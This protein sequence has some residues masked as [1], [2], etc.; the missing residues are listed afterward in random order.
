MILLLHIHAL[1][2]A[3]LVS[4]RDAGGHWSARGRIEFPIRA[5]YPQVALREGAAH[6]LAI[7]DI[8]EPVASW[9]ELKREKTGSEWDYVFRRLFYT[10]TPD[11]HRQ[12]FA[13]PLEVASVEETCGH[14]TNLD[15]HAG[16]DGA[17]HLLYLEAPHLHGFIRDRD[18][19]G[20]PMNRLLRYRQVVG[21]VAREPLTLAE[22]P[23]GKPAAGHSGL[24][25][26]YARFHLTPD[27]GLHVIL[28]ADVLRSDGSRRAANLHARLDG[29]GARPEFR[30]LALERPFAIF[31][32]SAPR[33]GA[34][35]SWTLDLF[36]AA[37]G[38]GN[39]LRYA[40]IELPAGGVE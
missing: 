2:S 3:Q 28:A 5:A 33:G 37:V 30:E 9:R 13:R 14:I 38:G 31:F 10:W 1:T 6:V 36:G 21:G 11:V 40:R 23:L 19:P 35:P 12:P 17:A 34:R 39:E 20:A 15:L 26:R 18:F 8:V 24:D 4:L 25:P 22:T 32:T 29:A 27:G 7:G 16:A